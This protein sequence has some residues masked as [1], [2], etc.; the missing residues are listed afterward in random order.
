[1]AK[2][3][4]KGESSGTRHRISSIEKKEMPIAYL[5]LAPALILL[6]IFV[7]V[8]LII[9]INRSFYN[10]TFYKE[11]EFVGWDSYRIIVT[12]PFFQQAV[13]NALKFVVIIVPSTLILTFLMGVFLKSLTPKTANTFKGIIYIPTVLSG[14]AASV[15]FRFVLDYR[16]GVINQA[17]MAMGFQRVAFLNS[18]WGATLAISVITLWM[19][20]GANTILMYAALNNISPSYYEA[21]EIDGANRFKQM[22]YVTIPQMKNIFILMTVSLT[23]G[24]LQMFDIP[25]MLTGGGPVN[26]TL[27]PMLYLYNNYRDA[28]KGMG[29]TIAGALI[30]M[31]IITALNLVIF[32]V[33]HSE[34]MVDG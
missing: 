10:W 23:T 31:V 18:P 4:R 5:M 13:K 33:I 29:Y 16:G 6:T 34:K 25:F 32:R 20:F 9:A 14:I 27:T 17:L 22:I 7:V 3:K 12:N 19:G 28:S 15:V 1:M 2:V 26:K 30:M 21:A 24:T 11:S 8:P